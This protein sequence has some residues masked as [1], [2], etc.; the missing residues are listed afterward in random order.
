MALVKNQDQPLDPPVLDADRP[1]TV[2]WHPLRLLKVIA[3]TWLLG[4]YLAANTLF[5]RVS[6]GGLIMKASGD[7]QSWLVFS[8]TAM[9]CVV[10]TFS[11]VP[12]SGLRMVHKYPPIWLLLAVFCSSLLVSLPISSIDIE[13]GRAISSILGAL[14]VGVIAVRVVLR[15]KPQDIV[16]SI[17]F[18]AVI[19]GTYAIVYQRQH[20]N[21][22]IS[23]TIFRA[24][25]T[26]ADPNQ[27]YF[28]MLIALPFAVVGMIQAKNNSVRFF[29]ILAC[30]IE[31]AA[32]VLTCSRGGLISLAV[33]IT[34][35]SYL[36]SH[37]KKFSILVSV[38]L[39]L[40]FGTV[41]VVR[42]A[43]RENATSLSRSDASRVRLWQEGWEK[44]VSHPLTGNGIGSFQSPVITQ[45]SN[46]LSFN[47][48]DEP[49]NNFLYWLD[50]LGIGG[51]FLLTFFALAIYM[52]IKKSLPHSLSVA[53]AAAWAGFF[54]AG[55]FDTPFGPPQRY[56][57]ACCFGLLLGITASLP[58]FRGELFHLNEA[59]T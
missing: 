21:Q 35:F 11:L 8:A 59:K 17:T 51:A 41:Q 55:L 9:L 46:Y 44:F 20:I 23:G 33:A 10:A 57:G 5:D 30:S 25:G 4:Y 2:A 36:A 42:M 24:G 18:S 52:I 32:I 16:A 3:S 47:N 34:L 49:K 28:L 1:A 53:T 40:L 48:I 14:S 45:N 27:L 50:A 39:F 13:Q 15:Y 58:E 19:Q 26:F 56:V 43:G 54:M 6:P 22:I 31:F 29:F 37:S 38:C 7:Y 12:V